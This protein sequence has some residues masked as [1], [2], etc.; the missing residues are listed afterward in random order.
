MQSVFFSPDST[1]P[2]TAPELYQ[3]AAVFISLSLG[4]WFTILFGYVLPFI[5]VIVILTRNG[6]AP[7]SD[8]PAWGNV[9]PSSNRGAPDGTI[10]LLKVIQYEESNETECCVSWL[11]VQFN[12][13]AHFV[14]FLLT[15]PSF[16]MSSQICM[17]EFQADDVIVMTDCKHVFH[18]KCCQEW[19][20][21]SRTC[22]VCR[23]DLAD[24]PTIITPISSNQLDHELIAAEEGIAI[25]LDRPIRS[26][27]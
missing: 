16:R 20:Q 22:P 5:C 7:T 19:L 18:R 12:F 24:P 23:T 10:D 1:C 17:E 21:H 9:F 11:L 15:S 3:T 27:T 14:N 8:M 6:Y 25:G 13:V 4:V 26:N 2:R